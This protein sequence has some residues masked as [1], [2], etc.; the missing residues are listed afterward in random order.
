MHAPIYSTVSLVTELFVS[1]GIVTAIVQAYRK[2]VFRKRLVLLTLAY[3]TL[4]NVS[5]MIYRVLTHEEEPHESK[6]DVG[7]AIFHGTLS[8]AMFIALIVFMIIAWKRYAKGV[9]FFRAHRILTGMFLF[10]WA[11]SI[12]SG[13]AF[14]FVEYWGP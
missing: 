7:L 11:L 1:A 4:F 6:I 12:L 3:E 10:L 2:N 9:N 8:L 5:Y 13:I 14:Y